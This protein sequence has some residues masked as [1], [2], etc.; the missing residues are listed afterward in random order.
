MKLFKKVLTGLFFAVLVLILL[1]L[2][3]SVDPTQEDL[4]YGVHQ[5]PDT[6]RQGSY[7]L[8]SLVEIVGTNKG[9]P[10][11]Y[12]EAALLAY[13]AYPEL[14]DVRIDMV[15]T[16]EGAPMES[17]FDLV[18]LLGPSS[19]RVYKILLNDADSSEFDEILLRSL[20]FNAQVG[21][22]AHELGHVAYYHRMSTLEI[23]KWGFKYATD[24]TFR[25]THE[26]TTDMM[27]IYHGMGSQIYQ[28]AW[29]VRND[30]STKPLYAQFGSLFIDKY[31]LT[32]Q[33]IATIIQNRQ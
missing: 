8:D 33:E 24:D 11:G 12:E 19:G 23:A 22:L 27:V 14:K 4:G 9:L 31:Y 17:N 3:Q 6:L 20:P 7:N 16:Q 25:A 32:D 26:K 28:Y 10:A 29:Y 21:I 30:P 18:T 2:I 1:V 5:F 15:L 13:S